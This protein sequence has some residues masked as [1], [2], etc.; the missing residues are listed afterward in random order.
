MGTKKTSRFRNTGGPRRQAYVITSMCSYHNCKRVEPTESGEYSN[1]LREPYK[2]GP[3]FCCGLCCD[4]AK[5]EYGLGYMTH[6][7][8]EEA[9]KNIYLRNNY[10]KN[11]FR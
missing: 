10:L 5:F 2:N 9:L 3:W 8:Y 7:Q 1:M 4:M 11:K 6:G